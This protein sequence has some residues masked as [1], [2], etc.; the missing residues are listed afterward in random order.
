MFA[1]EH[2]HAAA[3]PSGP[4]IVLVVLRYF[5]AV[6]RR[7]GSR[8]GGSEVRL[9]Q[10]TREVHR[11]CGT[12]LAGCSPAALEVTGAFQIRVA[13]WT[14][15]GFLNL[16]PSRVW[17]LEAKRKAAARTP[18]PSSSAPVILTSSHVAIER[19]PPGCKLAATMTSAAH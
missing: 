15:C 8:V 12:L 18:S 17:G 16:C 10:H 6:Q 1:T 2:E 14:Q 4:R 13:P 9:A 11:E 3:N 5:V 7:D 19:E